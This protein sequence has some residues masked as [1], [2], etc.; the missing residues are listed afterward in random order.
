MRNEVNMVTGILGSDENAQHYMV[1]HLASDANGNSITTARDLVKFFDQLTP[2]QTRGISVSVVR[3][4]G[5]DNLDR[6][7]KYDSCGNLLEYQLCDDQYGF[8]ILKPTYEVDDCGNVTYYPIEFF[9]Y[10]QDIKPGHAYGSVIAQGGINASLD[11]R[12][13]VTGPDMN[14]VGFKYVKLGDPTADIRAEYDAYSKM[15]VVY[16][17]E[18]TTAA[19]VKH[20]IETSEETKR[21]FEVSLPGNG[22]GFISLQDNYLLTKGGLFDAGYRGGA[23]MLGAA[24][25]DAHRLVLESLV[26]GSRQWVS[27]R[28]IVGGDFRITNADG[29]T[30][31]TSYG[32]D[33]KA[34]INGMNAKADGRELTLAASTLKMSV[35]LDKKV[36]TG[37]RIEFSITGGGALIQMGPN[38]VSNQQVRFGLQSMSSA[39]LGGGSGKLYQLREGE[40]ADLLTSDASRKLADRIVQEAILAVSRTRGRIGAIQKNTLEP[41]ITALQDSLVALTSAEAQ[42]SNA[43]FAEES[44]RLTRAQI[45]V[46]AGTRTLSIA[47]QFPQYAAS[48]LGG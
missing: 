14:G 41:Q 22:S 3:P 45:L 26:E 10:G 28:W 48:L 43:D 13:K 39:S 46:Q 44:S 19:Q 38:V 20:A 42:I 2:E 15:I 30:T 33:M 1:I 24:D 18:G 36:T 31:D 35:I 7:W 5:V 8:G 34:T 40:S 17:H 32:T 47:N 4:P 23:A 9:S 21:M 37:D 16:V 11:I 12:S 6:V 25:A 29:F 27:V